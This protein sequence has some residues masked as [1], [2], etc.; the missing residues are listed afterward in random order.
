[1]YKP[2]GHYVLV[3]PIFRDRTLSGLSIVNS[4]RPLE[5]T[6]R[7]IADKVEGIS[8]GDTVLVEKWAGK[9]VVVD[10]AK[11]YFVNETEVLVVIETV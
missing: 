7:A 2:L 9:E 5:M 6:V 11:C 3:E 8:V 10:G 4:E 1:M